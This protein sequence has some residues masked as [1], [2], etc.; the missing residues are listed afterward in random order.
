MPL[1]VSVL[2]FSSFVTLKTSKE[3]EGD[4]RRERKRTIHEKLKKQ[5]QRDGKQE[6]ERERGRRGVRAHFS[7][8]L[9]I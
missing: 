3:R 8:W 9:L 7:E 6:R 2:L 4:V 1:A 5:K